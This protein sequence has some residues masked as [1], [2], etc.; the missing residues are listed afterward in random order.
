MRSFIIICFLA[1]QTSAMFAQLAVTGKIT[2]ESG[3][4]IRS[5][6]VQLKGKSGSQHTTVSNE[7]GTFTISELQAGAYQLIIS[8]I[9]YE[10]HL[11]SIVLSGKPVE[12]KAVLALLSAELQQVEIIGRSSRKYNS[13][14]SF[15]AT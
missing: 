7:G 9:G 11:E 4:L 8:A 12:V 1:F 13:D 10:S 3:A 14:Y 2:D 6:T 15:G 5:A